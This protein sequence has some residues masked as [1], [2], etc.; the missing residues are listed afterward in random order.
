MA[1]VFSGGGGG[2]GGVVGVGW[3]FGGV[4]GGG[5]GWG[6]GGGGWGGGEVGGREQLVSLLN[7]KCVYTANHPD[8]SLSNLGMEQL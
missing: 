5:L 4:G 7:S 8:G 2:V 3:S 6:A 1:A